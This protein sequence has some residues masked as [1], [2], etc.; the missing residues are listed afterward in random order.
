MSLEQ[1]MKDCIAKELENG[2]VEKVIAQKLEECISASLKDMFSRNGDIKKVIDAKVKEVMIPYLEG[3]DYS[4]YIAKLD[5]VLIDVLN[6]TALEN[7]Q[8]L[9][10]FKELMVS[11]KT[12]QEI[13]ITDIYK[14]WSEYCKKKIDKDK[15]PNYDYEGGC[16]NVSFDVEEINRSW[17]SFEKHIIRFECEE[18][19]DLNIEFMVSKWKNSR[20]GHKLDWEKPADLKSLRYLNE[21]DMYMM[22]LD[23]A[24]VKVELDKYSDSDELFIEYEE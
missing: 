7:K 16:I 19:E 12:P 23:Q 11:D 18:D 14:K 2:I 1:N 15:I 22:K 6:T 13:K 17:S 5:S 4:K 21:F 24:Y 9:E 20:D 3:Y 8:L 10:N